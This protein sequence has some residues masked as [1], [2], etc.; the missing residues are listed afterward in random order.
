MLWN[1]S[2]HFTTSL[3]DVDEIHQHLYWILSFHNIWIGVTPIHRHLWN[4]SLISIKML[5]NGFESNS[6]HGVKWSES[7]S[8]HVVK[9]IRI[10]FTTCC[11]MEWLQ[12]TRC[13][14]IYSN[15]IHKMLW[16]GVNPFTRCCEMNSNPIQSML[17]NGFESNSQT[18]LK[19]VNPIHRQ[20]WL[21]SNSIHKMFIEINHFTTSILD[22]VKSFHNIFIGFDHFRKSLLNPII[23]QDVC[24]NR[25]NPIK[26]LWNG[27]T[28]VTRCCKMDS[29]PI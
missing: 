26:M 10:Q 12:F 18:S 25:S 11:E 27:F 29:N 6:E 3:L 7:N 17:W 5:W 1:V 20:L 19:W 9:W 8:Q 24:W 4:D 16:N 2:T 15:P 23:S 22:A 14:E 13:C 21:D 28:P